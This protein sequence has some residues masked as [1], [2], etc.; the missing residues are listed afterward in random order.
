M[1]AANFCTMRDFPL[2][3]KSYYEEAKRCPEC[4]TILDAD[5]E[6]CEVCGCEELEDYPYFDQF[7]ADEE[8]DAITSLM[9][10]FNR[11]LMFHK[12]EL[13]SGYY[14]GVQFYVE[15]EHDLDE[16]KDY[17]N[18]DCHYYFDCCRSVAYRKYAAEV[19]KIIRKLAAWGKEYGFQEYVCTAR[20]DNGEAWY[21]LA[22]NPRA[23]LKA[24]VA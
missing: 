16:D 15:T 7:L 10:D 14:T 20:F 2:F 17:T 1:S 5:A 22:S 8:W 11:D 9:E 19:R 4:D 18:D 21:E 6:T 12:V 24:A 3:A 23:R 13:R